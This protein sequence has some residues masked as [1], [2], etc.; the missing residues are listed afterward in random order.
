MTAQLL[1]LAP[2]PVVNPSKRLTLWHQSCT[3]LN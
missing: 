2:N 3:A 1:R